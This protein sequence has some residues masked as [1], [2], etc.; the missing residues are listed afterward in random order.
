M[1]TASLAKSLS[2]TPLGLIAMR[3]FL[4]L[5]SVAALLGLLSLLVLRPSLVSTSESSGPSTSNPLR[6]AS[7]DGLAG[8]VCSFPTTDP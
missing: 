4:W 7:S 6:D 5:V 1:P 2:K 3:I 8:A